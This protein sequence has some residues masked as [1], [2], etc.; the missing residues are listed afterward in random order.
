MEDEIGGSQRWQGRKSRL[1]WEQGHEVSDRIRR[2][3]KGLIR[4]DNVAGMT[5]ALR[6]VESP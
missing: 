3:M 4:E 5:P 2:Y 1:E 6:R